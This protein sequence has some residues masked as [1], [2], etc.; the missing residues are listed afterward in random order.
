MQL[1]KNLAHKLHWING[2]RARLFI[3]LSIILAFIGICA[4]LGFLHI[5]HERELSDIRDRGEI[6]VDVQASALKFPLW[7]LNKDQ[8]AALVDMLESADDFKGAKVIDP[9][10]KVIASI[11]GDFAPE[12]DFKF[13]RDI[14]HNHTGMEHNLGRLELYLSTQT[15]EDQFFTDLRNGIIALSLVILLM[16]ITFWLS[17]SQLVISPLRKLMS[18]IDHIASGDFGKKLEINRKDE[19]GRLATLFN[20]MTSEI[21]EMYRV[22]EQKVVERTAELTVTNKALKHAQEKATKAA[23]MLKAEKEKSERLLVDAL[24]ISPAAMVLLDDDYQI[25]RWN[26]NVLRLAPEELKGRLVVGADFQPI[27]D[28]IVGDDAHEHDYFVKGAEEAFDIEQRLSNGRWLK[29]SQHLTRDNYKALMLVDI[30]DMKDRERLL[31]QV[32]IDMAGQTEKLRQSEE[33]YALAAHGANDG[34]WDYIFETGSLYCSPR[35][36]EMLGYEENEIEFDSM[37]TWHEVIHPDDLKD[38]KRAFEAHIHHKIPRFKIEYRIRHKSGGYHW[39]LCRGL[40]AWT[41]DSQPIRIAGSQT[42]IT[43]QKNYEQELVHTAFHDPLTG[44]P[45]R[46]YFMRE[47]GGCLEKYKVNQDVTSAV[48]F[49]DLDRFKVVN[50]SLGHDVGDKLLIGISQRIKKCLRQSDFAARLGGDEF[51][52]LIRDIPDSTEA[53]A[54]ASRILEE[55]R[56]PF[57]IDG[58]EVFASASIGITLLADKIEDVDSLIRNA[59]LAMYRAKTTGKSRFEMFNQEMHTQIMDEMQVE[60]DL[61]RAIEK[62]EILLHYQPIVDIVSNELIGFEGLMRWHFK[63]ETMMNIGKFMPIAEDT[64]LILPIGEHILDIACQQLTE[65]TKMIGDEN[66]LSLAINL[67]TCQI[68]D[69]AYMKRFIK[70]IESYNIPEGCLKIEVT[71]SALMEDLDQ[72]KTILDGLKELGCP[73][74]IDDFG[75]GYSSFSYLHKFPFDVLKIDQSFIQRMHESERMSNMVRGIINLSHD[76]GL[77]VVGE[78]IETEEQAE[79]LKQ[80]RCDFG[81]GYLFAKPMPKEDATE[82]IKR[83][84]LPRT[85]Q[86]LIQNLMSHPIDMVDMDINIDTKEA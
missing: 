86:A 37:E 45:N 33:K 1:N 28:L 50:D 36:K 7:N 35:F 84:R 25:L 17:L 83:S 59:D 16:F 65:W 3:T 6:L 79:L 72:V 77:L 24:E 14:I 47:V 42:D 40:A 67:S 78:G 68:R 12:D 69:A 22:I 64:G 32:N 29:M 30:T 51:T 9:Q 38:F 70:K 56:V 57:P 10:N 82:F 54:V 23:E 80:L 75:T 4:L 76:M 66:K 27:F 63:R 15:L 62:D 49:I 11:G 2:I 52:V 73:L 43:M 5:S 26:Q 18:V 81:Q 20:K 55:L 85:E 34:L 41:D 46:E 48:L 53:E 8:V 61:R 60:T 74:C 21:S 13:R 71:E 19:F 31:E 39:M 58:H 44:L